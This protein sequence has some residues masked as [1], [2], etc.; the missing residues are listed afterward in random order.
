[1][2]KTIDITVS[3]TITNTIT[4]ELD[5]P[6]LAKYYSKNDNGRFD[7]QGVVLFA[8]IPKYEKNPTH[9]YNLVEVKRNKQDYN[10]F[11]PHDDCKQSFWLKGGTI[12]HTALD[13]LNN[14]SFDNWK[15]I[16]ADEFNALKEPLLN[17]YMLD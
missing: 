7:P 14:R 9:V 13:I 8:I 15:E 12:R 5:L 1:M 11:E 17:R 16:T 3:E 4:R 6:E 2:K 10:D